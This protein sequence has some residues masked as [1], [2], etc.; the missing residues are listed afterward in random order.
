MLSYLSKTITALCDDIA[1]TQNNRGEDRGITSYSDVTAFVFEQ[2]Q[3][4]PS[5]LRCPVLFATAVFG[6]SRLLIEGSFFYQ[7]PQERRHTQVDRWHRSKFGPNRDLMKF[8]TSLVVFALYSRR[9][10]QTNTFTGNV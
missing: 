10:S 8:Y 7:R 2:L 9:Q 1:A 3:K 4:M 6:M 5:F